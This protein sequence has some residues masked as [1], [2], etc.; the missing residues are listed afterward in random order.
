MS[1]PARR[2]VVQFVAADGLLFLIRP[3]R[4]ATTC[5]RFIRVRNR[6][7]NRKADMK[8][9][10]RNDYAEFT[11]MRA[12]LLRDYNPANAQ[13]RLLVME[14]ACAWRRLNKAREQEEHFFSLQRWVAAAEHNHAVEEFD[15]DGNEVVMWTK[16]KQ[17]GYDQLLTA[18]RDAERA[19]DR[20]I[21]R[22]EKMQ[23]DRF[24]RERTIRKDEEAREI[25]TERRLKAQLK[26]ANQLKR[27]KAA[28]ATATTPRAIEIAQPNR[29]LNTRAPDQTKQSA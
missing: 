26:T 11:Q 15:K 23:A 8:K 13:E 6:P 7:A 5:P 18:I 28:S 10:E 16:K 12:E 14:I 17:P 9:V 24:R 1:K 19:F 25:A 2:Y 3:I 29:V 20:A 4:T 27:Q 21:A 22:L